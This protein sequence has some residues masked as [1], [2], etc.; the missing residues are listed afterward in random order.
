M[1]YL[2]FKPFERNELSVLL[3]AKVK[4]KEIAKILNKDRSLLFSGMNFIDME[5]TQRRIVFSVKYSKVNTFTD[6]HHS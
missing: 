4:K 1:S 2:H 3:M 6:A 5:F